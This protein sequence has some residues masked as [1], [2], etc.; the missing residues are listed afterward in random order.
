MAVSGQAACEG[1]GRNVRRAASRCAVPHPY[2]QKE[3]LAPVSALNNTSRKRIYQLQRSVSLPTSR[4]HAKR[5]GHEVVHSNEPAPPPHRRAFVRVSKTCFSR[6]LRGRCRSGS[7]KDAA[8][9]V[10][11]KEREAGCMGCVGYGEGVHERCEFGCA[12]V[13]CGLCFCQAFHRSFSS[14]PVSSKLCFTPVAATGPE[15]REHRTAQ[16][17]RCT[18]WK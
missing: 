11:A 18:S 16:A 17:A 13:A 8:G 5:P 14:F 3:A 7:R 15:D 4:V 10:C 1:C 6:S 2:L 9:T 12:R